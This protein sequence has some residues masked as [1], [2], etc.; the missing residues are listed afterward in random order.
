MQQPAQLL[1]PEAAKAPNAAF[2][3]G[4]P[5]CGTTSFARYLKRHPQVSF[6]IVKEPHFFALHDLRGLPNDELKEALTRDYLDR[7]F[8][9]RAGFP[10]IAEGSVTSLYIPDRV[11]P[12]LKLFP[13]AKFIISV[14]NPLQMIPSLHQRLFY[15]GD[16]DVTDFAKA[17]ALVPERRAGRSVPK[18]CADPRWLDYW[19]S[20]MLGKYVGGFVQT[21]GRDRCFVSVFD[22]YVADPAAQYRR[23]LDFL[24]LED[25]G[26]TDF[27]R[28]R[29]SRGVKSAMLQRLLQRPPK[30]AVSLLGSEAY[31]LRIDAKKGEVGVAAR[32]VLNLRKRLLAWNKAPAPKI[33]LP[34]RL[35]D[36]MRAM[37]RDDVAKLSDLLGRDLSHWLAD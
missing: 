21:F 23:L 17:W 25:D 9:E 30:A 3:V 29:E 2:I 16:E 24:G 27:T 20:G 6:S 11:E 7:Y 33:V 31:K 1:A 35:K 18:R 22:D 32:T 8:P 26:R 28:H 36:E 13:D 5:R 4:A 10:L 19:E 15:N 12:V 37:Y 14:R 34:L